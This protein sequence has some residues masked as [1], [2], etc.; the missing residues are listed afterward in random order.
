MIVSKTDPDSAT[1]RRR[2]HGVIVGYKDH[3][4][5]DNKFGIVTATVATSGDYDDAALLP[6]L[7]KHHEQEL[8]QVPMLCAD[9]VD[10]SCAG[11]LGSPP[12]NDLPLQF[13]FRHLVPPAAI[14]SKKPYSP[15]VSSDAAPL[16]AVGSPDT[17]HLGSI[18]AVLLDHSAPGHTTLDAPNLLLVPPLLS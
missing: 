5:V 13:L 10:A 17:D 6:L 1:F 2:G 15:A 4:L 3:C 11:V 7:V 9:R 16:D 14:L 12:L 8:A 18:R